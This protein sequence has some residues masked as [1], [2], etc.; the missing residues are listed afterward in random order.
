MISLG[1]SSIDDSARTSVNT[2]AFYTVDTCPAQVMRFMARYANRRNYGNTRAAVA[3]VARE[4]IEILI[5]KAR[6]MV[7][8]DPELSRRYVDLARRISE[9]TKV[10]IPGDL[11][12]YL[13][14]SCGIPMVPGTNARVRLRA[15]DGGVVI[16]CL[17]CGTVK[18]YPVSRRIGAR[19]E[20]P[21]IKTYIVQ[22]EPSS[23]KNS[24]KN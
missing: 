18:R 14:K 1:T 9:R 6:E 19:S 10:R 21:A 8:K 13:C 7:E 24:S 22:S 12:R 17:T 15:R 16:T 3:S 5:T 11:K 23:K 4:R 20:R 2:I